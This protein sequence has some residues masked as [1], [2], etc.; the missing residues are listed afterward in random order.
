MRRAAGLL[1]LALAFVA[2]NSA[3]RLAGRTLMPIA[4]AKTTVTWTAGDAT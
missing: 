3:V 4:P 2:A 1:A